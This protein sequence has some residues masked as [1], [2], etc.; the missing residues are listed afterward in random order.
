MNVIY[1]LAF[2]YINLANNNMLYIRFTMLKLKEVNFYF[3]RTVLGGETNQIM[4]ISEK[5]A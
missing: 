2:K 4:K 1:I 3:Q 5:Y